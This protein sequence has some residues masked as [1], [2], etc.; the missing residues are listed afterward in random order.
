VIRVRKY[1]LLNLVL[2]L[3]LGCSESSST[4]PVTAPITSAPSLSPEVIDSSPKPILV[5][6]PDVIGLQATKGKQQLEG[7]DLFVSVVERYSSQPSG[8]ILDQSE[9]AGSKLEEGNTIKITVAKSFPRVPNLVGR[10]LD[11]ARRTLKDPGFDVR[12]THETSS[13]RKDSVIRMSP[14]P[15]TE[16]RPHRDDR[17]SEA[18]PGPALGRRRRWRL[19]P[20]L[21]SLPSSGF[22]LR[23]RRR[24]GRRAK[25]HGH[26]D[27]HGVRSVRSRFRQRRSRV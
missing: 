23:L 14:S 21:L 26:S 24:L 13:Q 22:G 1:L 6:V 15:G 19:H 3:A 20:W 17:D 8:T 10:S 7:A 4:V 11:Y 5:R 16:A 12:V 25:V 2:V 9:R 27:G 18:S